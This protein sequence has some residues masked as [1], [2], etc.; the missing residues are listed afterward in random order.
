[1]SRGK[2]W[3]I[4]AKKTDADTPRLGLA[5]SKKV[6]RLAV[7]R[8]KRKRIAREVFRLNQ[9]AFKNWEFVVMSKRSKPANNTAIT[10]DLLSLFNKATTH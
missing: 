6:H 5:I 7:E 4:I 10:H 3:Q 1:M 2:Y 9:D 8:N